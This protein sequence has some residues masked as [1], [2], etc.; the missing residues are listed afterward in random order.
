MSWF[1]DLFAPAGTKSVMV[2]QDQALPG[3]DAVMPVPDA[4][5]V[6]GHPLRPPF[7]DG[8]QTA[9]VGMGC[10]WG[11]EKEFWELDGVYSTAVGY[12][13]GFTPNPTYEEVCSGRTGHSEVVLVVFDPAKI[14]YE[15]ILKQ[16]WENHD[17]TQGMRQGNDRG[18]Q[19]RSVIYTESDEQAETARATAEAFGKRLAAAGYGEITTEIAPLDT[20]YYAEDY[21]QQY[22]AKNPGGYCPVHATGVSCPVGLGA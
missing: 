17:P 7:P 9:V 3:R 11:A 8:M 1:D 19:Y 6:N 5:Y 22:L 4:H 13:G 16:F 20:F 14:S 15:G 2:T 12:A 10:F 18:T 21:H